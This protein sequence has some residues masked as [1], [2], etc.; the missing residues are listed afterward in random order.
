MFKST[1]CAHVSF[2][3]FSR[4]V[5]HSQTRLSPRGLL[6]WFGG[7]KSKKSING[8][9]LTH[10]KKWSNQH[11][12]TMSVF[13][14][15]LEKSNIAKTGYVRM[16]YSVVLMVKM[17]KMTKNDQKWQKST[18]NYTENKALLEVKITVLE[19]LLHSQTWL[20]DLRHCFWRVLHGQIWLLPPCL[21]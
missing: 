21:T 3:S 7:Q 1:H 10:R 12:Q 20:L 5:K 9:K 4:K 13:S 18:K 17:T 8:G 14:V 16:V 15:F 19:D 2:F 11:I 6:W